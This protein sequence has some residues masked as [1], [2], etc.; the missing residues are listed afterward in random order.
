MNARSS[1]AEPAA[2]RQPHPSPHRSRVGRWA[3]WF[4]LLG[5]ASAW[6]LQEL[7]NVSLAGHACYPRD[8]PLAAPLWPHL[9]DIAVG[10]EVV[11]IVVCAL[12]FIVAWRNWRRSRH[13]KAGDVHQLLGGGDGR[14]R[15]MAM[16]GM[17]VS[18]V[19]LFATALATLNLA[20]ISPCGG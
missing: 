2:K 6:S 17:M 10:V 11:A 4:G 15:F 16:S 18:A 7:V 14:T 12:A 8:V 20:G 9:T 13:E 5:A 1:S 19:F 3:E